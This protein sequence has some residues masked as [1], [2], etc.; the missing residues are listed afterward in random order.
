MFGEMTAA[1]KESGDKVVEL[2]KSKKL[3]QIETLQ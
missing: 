3:K 2:I 1:V